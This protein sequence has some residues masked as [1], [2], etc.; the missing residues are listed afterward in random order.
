MQDI[1]EFTIWFGLGFLMLIISFL[2]SR[3]KKVEPKP[4]VMSQRMIDIYRKKKGFDDDKI[5]HA[6]RMQAAIFL[7]TGGTFVF[8]GLLRL[9]YL[10]GPTL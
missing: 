7:V 10:Y 4:M 2:N 6:V 8:I 3:Y 5:L 1:I 9:L